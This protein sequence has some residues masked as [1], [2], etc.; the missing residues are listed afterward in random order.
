M[1]VDFSKLFNPINN[2]LKLF[3]KQWEHLSTYHKC[4]IVRLLDKEMEG[5]VNSI[6]NE[7]GFN[8]NCTELDESF[9]DL[10]KWG[11]IEL[12]KTNDYYSAK[13]YYKIKLREFWYNNV[14]MIEFK[15][16]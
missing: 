5:T 6:M 15:K 11:I 10:E 1:A 14:N 9:Y 3:V 12:T 4:I 7:V 8:D 2:A 13:D 16:H